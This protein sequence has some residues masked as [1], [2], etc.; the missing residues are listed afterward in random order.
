MPRGDLSKRSAP[1]D[2]SGASVT[3]F[4]YIPVGNV[5][6]SSAVFVD[7]LP[8]APD[9]VIALPGRVLLD[10]TAS[11]LVIP[12]AGNFSFQGVTLQFLWDGAPLVE[13]A[14]FEI[15]PALVTTQ[16]DTY[17]FEIRLRALVQGAQAS[18]GSHTLSVQWLTIDPAA[19]LNAFQDVGNLTIEGRP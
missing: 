6:T 16:F 14:F 18:V 19:T 8:V 13:T 15:D 3:A 1:P 2:Q 12:P 17:A 7:L 5:A 9:V 11:I 4:R 10:F